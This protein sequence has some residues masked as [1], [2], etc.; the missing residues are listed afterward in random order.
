M[1]AEEVVVA[2]EDADVS[3]E[4]VDVDCKV[5]VDPVD[6]KVQVVDQDVDGDALSD[7]DVEHDVDADLCCPL[8]SL[9]VI[10]VVEVVVIDDLSLDD[11]DEDVVRKVLVVDAS[12]TVLEVDL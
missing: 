1:D 4:D 7:D 12:C 3:D 11:L 5:Q 6:C 10:V 2:A 8:S 9:V